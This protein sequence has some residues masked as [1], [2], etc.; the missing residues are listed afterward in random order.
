VFHA[1][2]GRWRPVSSDGRRGTATGGA[3]GYQPS[4][5]VSQM[6]HREPR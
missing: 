3:S 1:A 5:G 4:H 6:V 2:N